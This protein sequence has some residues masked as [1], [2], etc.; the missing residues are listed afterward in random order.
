MMVAC[1]TLELVYAHVEAVDERCPGWRV[2][3]SS[4]WADMC[5]YIVRL[6]LAVPFECPDG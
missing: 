5:M 4:D 2:G 1:R 6:S 3:V